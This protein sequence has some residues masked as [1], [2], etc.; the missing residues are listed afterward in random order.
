MQ[1]EM[2]GKSVESYFR[3]KTEGTI[4]NVCD[5]CRRFGEVIQAVKPK[6]EENVGKAQKQRPEKPAE[7]EIIEDLVEGYAEKIKNKR[8]R[9]GLKQEELAQKINE[10]ESIIHKI[11][12]GHF[13]PPIELAKKLERFL[14]IKIIEDV[15]DVRVNV[16]QK[17]SNEGF[18]L[19]D[20]I[21]VKK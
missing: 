16:S 21:K 8:E 12:S 5:N 18:S 10:K 7:P 15:E 20:F 6:P 9:L 14:G 3:V 2:C 11:E 13:T 19:G 17:G 4:L 1:C